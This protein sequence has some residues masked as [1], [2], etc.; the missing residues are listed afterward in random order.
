MN[1]HDTIAS[2]ISNLRIKALV[3]NVAVQAAAQ[4]KAELMAGIL[5]RH[6]LGILDTLSSDLTDALKKDRAKA[7]AEAEASQHAVVKNV[8]LLHAEELAANAGA[9]NSSVVGV[10]L[11][12]HL[13]A[14]IDKNGELSMSVIDPATGR[15]LLNPR[16]GSQFTLAQYIAA[17]KASEENG[18]LFRDGNGKR[19]GGGGAQ[20]PWMA[21]QENLTHQCLLMKND[22]E[23]GRR[24]KAEAGKA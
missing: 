13:N 7:E 5:S 3:Q 23:T 4:A 20:N 6:E 16:T 2:H 15:A 24:L 11:Q 9:I 8:A 17:M 12:E 19:T 21:G 1:L 14:V 10:A 22:R 18:Y